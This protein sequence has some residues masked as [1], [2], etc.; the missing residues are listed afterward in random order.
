MIGLRFRP[1]F[2]GF[3]IALLDCATL[4]PLPTGTCGNGVVEKNED[5]DSFP[6]QQCGAPSDGVA[7][8]RLLCNKTV[9]D[10]SGQDVA[11]TCPDGWGCSVQNFCRAPAGDFQLADAPFSAGVTRLEVGD[12]DGDRRADIL[13]TNTGVS[14]GR[15]HYINV[16]GD[17]QIV[18]LPGVLASPSVFDF[19]GDGRSDIAF[20][21]SGPRDLTSTDQIP[22]TLS[23][24]DGLA[25]I[26]GQGDR[27]VVPQLFPSLSVPGADAFIIPLAVPSRLSAPKNGAPLVAIA[28]TKGGSALISL[29]GGASYARA[30]QGAVAG[31]AKSGILL[32]PKKTPSACGEIVI[33]LND[34]IR[35]NRVE[36][37]SPCT[38]TSGT[39][40]WAPR[41]EPLLIPAAGTVTGVFI[42]DVDAD[43]SNDIIIGTS[44]GIFVAYGSGT[45][46][47]LKPAPPTLTDVP[48]AAGLINVGDVL[49]FVIPSGVLISTVV[50][51][52]GG[53]GG[54]GLGDDGGDGGGGGG[55]RLDRAL[56]SWSLLRSPKT[57]TVAEVADLNRDGA[58]DVV[59][60]SSDEAD[61]DVL[62]GTLSRTMPAFTVSTDGPVTNLAVSDFDFDATNDVAFV[63]TSAASTVREIGISYGR[64]LA[65]PPEDPRIAGRLDGVRQLFLQDNGIAIASVTSAALDLAVLLKSTERQPIAPLLFQV[66]DPKKQVPILAVRSLTTMRRGDNIDLVTVLGITGVPVV[67][68]ALPTFGMW[69]AAGTGLL[70]FATPTE[71]IDLAKLNVTAPSSTETLFR[72]AAADLGDPRGW[73]MVIL[74]PNEAGPGTAIRIYPPGGP[75]GANT[76]PASLPGI[77]AL[78]PPLIIADRA[79]FDGSH[80]ELRDVDGDGI[81]DLV[82]LLQ[83]VTTTVPSVSIFFG[84][85]KQSFD[86]AGLVLTLPMLAGATADELVPQGF[87]LITTAG[88]PLGDVSGAFLAP[89]S[90]R[91]RELMIVT[92]SH[93]FRA[94][95]D[96]SRKAT[97]ADA[98]TI[99]GKIVAAAAIVTGDFDGDGIPDLAISDQSAIRIV[100]QNAVL[101]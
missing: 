5:C 55:G 19:D 73:D 16:G 9:K 69:A 23:Q 6:S 31:E 71:Q 63:T 80:V 11:L 87:V 17:P 61:L 72:S 91:R 81:Q 64:V 15:I 18:T 41:V 54:L 101:P 50:G 52:L 74:S 98:T 24:S 13:G 46:F 4:T 68:K 2:F 32:D 14:R 10:A 38:K 53:D 42:A 96:K 95:V 85:G 12:F 75:D 62:E 70:S 35:G 44:A 1:L 90:G 76:P 40:D 34:V 21:Y 57:W 56:L 29:D 77:E 82:A 99:Y 84:T 59:G 39:V 97:I 33:G 45:A 48:L 49:D 79:P 58:P 65:M 8:C 89:T 51:D 86:P 37:Y 94:F 7:Q 88:A 3:V 28:S 27:A 60:A 43:G 83:D 47:D 100:R 26:L 67:A 36:V 30:L 92:K 20:G 78:A 93:L 25:I 66:D 22:G